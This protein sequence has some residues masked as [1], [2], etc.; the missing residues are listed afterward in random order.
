MLHLELQRGKVGM[1]K[2][3]HHEEMGATVGCTVRLAEATMKPGDSC[4][5]DSWFGSVKGCVKLAEKGYLSLMNVKSAHGLF[6]LNVSFRNG[7]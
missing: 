4:I 1:K 7:I 2:M 3:E 6:P 5:A